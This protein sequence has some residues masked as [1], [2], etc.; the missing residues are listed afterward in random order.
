MPSFRSGARG[1]TPRRWLLAACLGALA[2]K[3]LPAGRYVVRDVRLN[4]PESPDHSE[5]LPR[6]A[7]R[8]TPRFLGVLP[9]TV[10][11]YEVFD[12]NVLAR[13]L[14]RV[15]RWYRSR[16]YYEAHVTAARV[17]HVT[18]PNP[19]RPGAPYVR[20]EIRVDPG[21]PVLTRKI[22][23]AGVE[24]LPLR[25][26]TRA[27]TAVVTRPQTPFDEEEYEASKKAI[28]RALA[29]EGYA[30]AKVKGQ[31]AIDVA[32][33]V[34]DVQFSI[35]PGPRAEFGEIEILGLKEIPKEPVLDSIYIRPGDPYSLSEI[36]D[37][38]AALVNLGVFATVD[39][40]EDKTRPEQRR[41][42]ITF[43]VQESSLRALR[44]GIG[45]RIDP[46]TVSNHVRL[47]WQDRNFLGGM[48]DV[49]VEVRPTLWYFPLKSDSFF[50]WVGN[51]E[52]LEV[53]CLLPGNYAL[54]QLRRPSFIEARTSL[55][56]SGE[57]NIYPLLFTDMTAESPVI[58][59]NEIKASVGLE[60]AFFYHHLFVNPSLNFQRN[61]P[62]AYG[63][64]FGQTSANT[65]A[66]AIELTH[67]SEYLDTVQ[68]HYPE[69]ITALDFRDDAIDPRQGFFLSNSLQVAGFG[70]S[71][72]DVRVLP[73]ARAYVPLT[74]SKDVV[75]AFRGSVGFLFP[76]D[77]SQEIPNSPRLR[78]PQPPPEGAWPGRFL[79]D[80]FFQCPETDDDYFAMRTPIVND[81]HKMLFRAFYSGGQNSNR[82]YGPREVGPHGPL[83]ILQQGG[84]ENCIEN[85]DQP[86]CIRPLGGLSLWES[87]LELRFPL[88]GEWRGVTFVDASN[89]ALQQFRLDFQA[90]HFSIGFGLR[91]LT[92]VGPFRLDVG[93][94]LPGAQRLAGAPPP[95]LRDEADNS[96]DWLP[97]AVHISLGEAF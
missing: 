44:A 29:D 1:I 15:E 67:P 24:G 4:A 78:C 34:A 65:N 11:E 84:A 87:S 14:Q 82:G 10:F 61:D 97:V 66:P 30:F 71:V 41:V 94:P 79:A 21:S 48:R 85:P 22:T 32:T 86:L 42:P 63:T 6:L 8:K 35:D 45:G 3:P 50:Q 57:F 55:S 74:R 47:G 58:K 26:A 33:H 64:R 56:M 77:Y 88:L 27:W 40:H 51:Q 9:E 46:L 39:V 92:P 36:E 37:A 96:D 83:G 80:P 60:R 16:G 93:Y 28:L 19:L 2:C 7:T 53:C 91:Y 25:D 70:G 13:D 89:V 23:L 43:R 76:R 62:A 69:L 12:E 20:V 81:Q 38:H 90:P 73:D 52:P 49:L 95:G 18:G 59:Y 5:L 31:A 72:S 54:L 75:L 17:E 68:V